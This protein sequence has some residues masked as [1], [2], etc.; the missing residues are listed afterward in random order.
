[1]V[2][3]PSGILNGGQDILAFKVRIVI[4]HL[5]ECRSGAQQFKHVAYANPHAP[6]ARATAALRG[7]D[8]YPVQAIW[9]H[10]VNLQPV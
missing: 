1:M 6:N 3:L 2:G 4:Q 5:V 10:D 7:V 9:R 8:G